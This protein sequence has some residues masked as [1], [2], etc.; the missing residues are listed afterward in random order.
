MAAVRGGAGSIQLRDKT[1][2][3]REFHN[4]AVA[5]RRLTAEAGVPFVVNDRVHVAVA[6]GSDAVHVGQTDMPVETVRRVVGP[7]MIIGVSAG[8]IEEALR[9]KAEGADYVGFGPVWSTATKPDASPETGLQILKSVCEDCTAPVVAI[10]GI[11]LS[12]VE[13]VAKA[14]A[15][16]AAV[17]SAVVCAE[18]MEA[19]TRELCE[20][21]RGDVI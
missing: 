4:A 8:S 14:G 13:A 15:V 17:V 5:I 16:G 20:R 1:C 9:A 12:R 21:F 2:S 10:G 18:D 11:G 19:A 3:D 7:D 6:V